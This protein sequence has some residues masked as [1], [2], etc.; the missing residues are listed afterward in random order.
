MALVFCALFKI[1]IE[2]KTSCYLRS[3]NGGFAFLVNCRQH[4]ELSVVIDHCKI[5]KKPMGNL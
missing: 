5:Q 4:M 2:V 3:K 1:F